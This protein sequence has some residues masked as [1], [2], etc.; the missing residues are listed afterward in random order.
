MSFKTTLRLLVAACLLAFALWLAE[1]KSRYGTRPGS[2]EKVLGILSEAVRSISIEH[3]DFTADCSLRDGKWFIDKPLRARADE[4]EISHILNV[5]ELL[6]GDE[7]I[8]AAQRRSRNLSL[9]N[10][11]LVPPRARFVLRGTTFRKEL[12]VG[13]DAPLGESLYVKVQGDEGVIATSRSVLEVIPEDMDKL[14][15]RTLIY[16]QAA[17]TRRLEIQR[18][19]V[20]F[21]QLA[22]TDGR[23]MIQQPVVARAGQSRVVRMLNSL[24]S[25]KVEKFIW[26][27]PVKEK[28]EPGVDTAAQEELYDLV[29]DRAP[30]RIGVW[31][32]RDRVGR[33]LILG[34]QTDDTGKLVYAKLRDVG[35]IY[36]IDK[37]ILDVFSVAVNDLRDRQM[38]PV[39]ANAV[40]YVRFE[41]GDRKLILS[42]DKKEGWLMTEPVRWKAD[43]RVVMAAIA[44][45]TAL[46]AAAFHEKQT[47][48][49]VVGLAPPAYTMQLLEKPPVEKQP[50]VAAEAAKERRNCLLIATMNPKDTAVYA[51]LDDDE[52]VCTLRAEPVHALVAHLTDPLV[53]R[54]R[55][56]L[57]VPVTSVK[58]I[59]LNRAG[60]TQEIAQGETGDWV[61]SVPATNVVNRQV[62]EDILFHVANMRALRIESHNPDSLAAYGLD[63]PTSV[64]TLGL[65]GEQGI[66]KSLMLGFRAKTDG[67]YAMVQGQDVVFVLS[68]EMVDE[69]MRDISVPPGKRNGG[70]PAAGEI[71]E[72]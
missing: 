63:S 25:L 39:P 9:E 5:L 40:N 7:I 50:A 59:T 28:T 30:A 41:E 34:K 69:L 12:L 68:N 52:T 37:G 46:R 18:P 27:M 13:R 33:E 32:A 21:I 3:G 43:D 6:Q 2:G 22:Q 14:R 47:N 29:P 64:L 61:S 45:A 11:G 44:R 23:W 55:T 1:K 17:R 53:Y 54:D 58:R 57:A 60:V 66:Q 31:V 48:L 24:Y 26:D 36:A 38:F 65:V 19:G 71:S 67:I 16:G 4:G 10:Y 56:V 15:D 35:S 72:P 62:V 51:K 42:W 20:G 70:R 8:T 49:T